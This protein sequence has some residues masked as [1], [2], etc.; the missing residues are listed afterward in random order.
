MEKESQQILEVI[1]CTKLAWEADSANAAKKVR[2]IR[3]E[4]YKNKTISSNSKD[5]TVDRDSK[6]TV[7]G[8]QKFQEM[9]LI[10]VWKETRWIKPYII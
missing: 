3:T 8:T 1:K 6:N 5:Q 4:V 7:K 10:Y 9:F 2:Y